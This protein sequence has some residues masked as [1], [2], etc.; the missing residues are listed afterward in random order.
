M[1]E[2]INLWENTPGMCEEIP[3]IEYYKPENKRSDAAVII[4]PG[5]GYSHR[6]KH[7]GEGYAEFLNSF[8]ITAFVVQYRVSPHR[9]P[10]E[11]LDARRSVRFVRFFADKFGIDKNK[12]CV[13]GSSAGGH[14]A[15]LV[16]TYTEPIEFE[17]A[18]EIDKEEFL[19]NKQI[20]CY[21][22]IFLGQKNTAHI[23]SGKN[24]LGESYPDMWENCSPNLIAG[25]KTPDAF[26][27]HTFEDG[28]VNVVNSLEYAKKLKELNKKVEMHIF[29]DGH[30]GMGLAP[31]I[32]GDDEYANSTRKH[33]SKW[34]ELLINWLKYIDYL[35]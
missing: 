25:E 32:P 30:H 8:G 23:G 34:G 7:E 6:A 16:S 17:N 27:W 33:V 26:I 14:L 28:C 1:N 18:D 19:P 3:V 10:L 20:L 4:F 15:A 31:E 29:P 9:F 35:N 13:M 21:P 11:L 22:V 24:L 5:G 2:R 12:V